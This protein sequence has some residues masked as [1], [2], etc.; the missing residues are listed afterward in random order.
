MQ[1]AIKPTR[2]RISAAN[3]RVPQKK[4]AQGPAPGAEV[5]AAPPTKSEKAALFGRLGRLK[6]SLGS[7]VNKHEAAI[8]LISA[9]IEEGIRTGGGIVGALVTLGFNN[10]HV[11]MMLKEATGTSPEM[12]RWSR[13]QEGRYSLI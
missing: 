5:K 12:H 4:P 6:A 1:T 13:D 11:A 8:V 9:C 10:K 2:P 3:L 7:G